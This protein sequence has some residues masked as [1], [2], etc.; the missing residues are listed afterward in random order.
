[1]KQTIHFA[2]DIHIEFG[3]GDLVIPEGDVLL[4]AGDVMTLYRNPYES[5]NHHDTVMKRTKKF[6]K[7]VSERNTQVLYCFGNHEHYFG[8][9]NNTRQKTINFFEG[10]GIDN[11]TLMD[12]GDAVELDD[13]LVWGDTFWTDMRRADPLIMHMVKY[14]LNDYYNTTD[15]E[16][17]MHPS[18]T[19]SLNEASRDRLLAFLNDVRPS[20]KSRVV[21]THHAPFF[22]SVPE[23]FVTDDLN[24]AYANTGIEYSD[25]MLH[26][27]T[28]IHGH[29]H[30]PVNYQAEGIKVISSPR[31]YW[32]SKE[33]KNFTFKR[34]TDEHLM[35]I[36]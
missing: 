19:I 29:M 3:F 4:L 11:V 13:V 22:K 14:G 26:D 25:V 9:I 16:T 7:Q 35:P 1:M 31:G 33:T 17:S 2:S 6:W 21:M 27:F 34:L 23:R 24:F 5:H 30:D 12:G 15:G 32:G 20:N 10:E 8:D 18:K 36:I 28:W